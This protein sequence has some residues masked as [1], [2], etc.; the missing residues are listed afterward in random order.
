MKTSEEKFKL[1]NLNNNEKKEIINPN[2]IINKLEDFSATNKIESL[3]KEE[4]GVPQIAVKINFLSYNYNS[5]VNNNFD[6]LVDPIETFNNDLSKTKSLNAVVKRKN[7][8]NIKRRAKNSKSISFGTMKE[9][10]F[11]TI[12]SPNNLE[13]NQ[14]FY[15]NN[16]ITDNDSNHNTPK[17]LK[18]SFQ[19]S[20]NIE[21]SLRNSISKFDK[22]NSFKFIYLNR[23]E[24]VLFDVKN[25]LFSSDQVQK[26]VL[27]NL[28]VDENKE[29]QTDNNEIN[30]NNVPEVNNNFDNP[31]FKSTNSS[32]IQDTSFNSKA[33]RRTSINNFNVIS[34]KLFSIANANKEKS[35]TSKNK[36]KNL[37]AES[38]D[39]SNNT[40]RN[41]IYLHN[42]SYQNIKPNNNM[43]N[44]NNFI[45]EDLIKE[46]ILKTERSNH[47]ANNSNAENQRR[48][49]SI[50][51]SRS[52]NLLNESF[53]DHNSKSRKR[54]FN[55]V[56]LIVDEI[57]IDNESHHNKINI[58][59]II[60]TSEEKITKNF[61]IEKEQPIKDSYGDIM[62]GI[63][64]H[65]EKIINIHFKNKREDPIY[66]NRNNALY[67]KNYKKSNK[68]LHR[69]SLSNINPSI[70][71]IDS[72]TKY[73]YDISTNEF[74]LKNNKPFKKGKEYQYNKLYLADNDKIITE[75][76][77]LPDSS[78]IDFY[79][80]ENEI[81]DNPINIKDKP[82][83]YLKDKIKKLIKDSNKNNLQEIHKSLK[84]GINI[85]TDKVDIKTNFKS[86]FKNEKEESYGASKIRNSVQDGENFKTFVSNK[87][88]IESRKYSKNITAIKDKIKLGKVQANNEVEKSIKNINF[89]SLLRD[90][91]QNQ[92]KDFKK[93]FKKSFDNSF[94]KKKFSDDFNL[95]QRNNMRDRV[96][97]SNITTNNHYWKYNINLVPSLESSFINNQ[98]H[99]NKNKANENKTS[100]NKFENNFNINKRFNYCEIS[101]CY[102]AIIDDSNVNIDKELKNHHSNNYLINSDKNN[103]NEDRTKAI[104]L[105]QQVTGNEQNFSSKYKLDEEIKKICK[106]KCNKIIKLHPSLEEVIERKKSFLITNDNVDN[107]N[108]KVFRG[109]CIENQINDLCFISNFKEKKRIK[110][111][112]KNDSKKKY[113]IINQN[114]DFLITFNS[115][116]NDDNNNLVINKAN[117]H[118]DLSN[119]SHEELSEIVSSYEN[120]ED[121]QDNLDI[122]YLEKR[123]FSKSF[124]QNIGER[125]GLFENKEFLIYAKK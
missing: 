26:F 58:Y 81:I 72:L 5:N 67:P 15:N 76:D 73:K 59:N 116:H 33:I 102:P 45:L 19:N 70:I 85:D 46:D 66:I 7:D 56:N 55:Q 48:F 87:S 68:K 111:Q 35:F 119:Q 94:F 84:K 29:N 107:F 69:K 79:Y 124:K 39:E 27:E 95:S 4:N 10:D 97:S 49:L 43:S 40:S 25:R 113:K 82:S 123:D 99:Y 17:L 117:E 12:F 120:N 104:Y 38:L 1:N 44:E 9:N 31:L 51:T 115:E 14:N 125:V 13:K 63:N 6:Y 112:H 37:E 91:N 21:N 54:N 108:K 80:L 92:N 50:N 20:S 75:K 42:D 60:Q 52:L 74:N 96:F 3:N 71:D 90:K 36:N 100:E 53:E 47:Y 86:N 22:K 62:E 118:I 121:K 8:S 103:R 16:K 122:D 93:E 101:D 89:D 24:K 78:K 106:D 105:N 114:A 64:I 83:P 98:N 23:S 30:K 65:K 2:P 110:K 109:I 34:N 11:K 32:F 88:D 18:V 61:I 57:E 77:D 41:G 28:N